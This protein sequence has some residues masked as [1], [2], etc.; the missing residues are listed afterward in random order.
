MA[1]SDLRPVSV[2]RVQ[3]RLAHEIKNG[4]TKIFRTL[5]SEALGKVKALDGDLAELE[6]AINELESAYAELDDIRHRVRSRHVKM[7][8][9]S[10]PQLPVMDANYAIS[11]QRRLA[12]RKIAVEM[13][14]QMDAAL[15][16][17]L[18]GG[19]TV[20]E[21]EAA[22]QF[23]IGAFPATA[24][25]AFAVEAVKALDKSIDRLG[26]LRDAGEQYALKV[27]IFSMVVGGFSA[28]FR[29]LQQQVDRE[30]SDLF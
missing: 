27:E 17:F 15:K 21:L 23:G 11:V 5:H 24:P 9:K 29:T 30:L 12:A 6:G 13:A 16:N 19:V 8:G 7:F 22:A 26:H 4:P 10:S 1:K 2:D 3:N 20:A 25:F 14:K 28:L 18:D